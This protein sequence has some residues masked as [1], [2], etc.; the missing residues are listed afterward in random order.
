MQTAQPQS[1]LA[2]GEGETVG[3]T[4]AAPWGVSRGFLR[5]WLLGPAVLL[6]NP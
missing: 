4:R 3:G 5:V 1:F 2:L 6:W